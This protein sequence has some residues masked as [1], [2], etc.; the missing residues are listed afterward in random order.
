MLVENKHLSHL[1][2]DHDKLKGERFSEIIA[3][4]PG[5]GMVPEGHLFGKFHAPDD[6]SLK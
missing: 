2:L 4:L 3:S 6:S 1:L 5:F